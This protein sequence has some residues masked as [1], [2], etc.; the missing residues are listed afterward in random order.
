MGET[1]EGRLRRSG[2]EEEEGGRVFRHRLARDAAHE[3]N[4]EFEALGMNIGGKRFEADAV[5]GGGEFFDCVKEASM[6]VHGERE[7]GECGTGTATD[8]ELGDV[9]VHRRIGIGWRAFSSG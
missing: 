4:A 9:W 6:G 5:G 2:C 1:A 7:R 3:V 8:L